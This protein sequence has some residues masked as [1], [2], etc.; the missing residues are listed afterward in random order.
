MRAKLSIR[1]PS[2]SAKLETASKRI[3]AHATAAAQATGAQIVEMLTEE[4]QQKLSTDTAR[5][6]VAGLS[7]KP[8]D[9]GV[10]I[11]LRGALPLMIERGA[12]P[13]DMKPGLLRKAKV[14]KTGE[15]Y[16]DVPIGKTGM[17]RRVSTDSPVGS[18]IHPGIT[19][20]NL[21]AQLRGRLRSKLR[22]VLLEQLR[23]H[24]IIPA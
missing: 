14:S 5:Q 1:I 24:G 2:L 15:R 21:L 7:V 23:K 17:I 11:Q 3:A 10:Q 22:G 4:A 16:Q 18:W 8:V 19:P 9:A 13:F 6:Y 12:Q 20:L